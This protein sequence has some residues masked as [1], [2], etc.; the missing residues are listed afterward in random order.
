MSIYQQYLKLKKEL[1]ISIDEQ[2]WYNLIDNL[3]IKLAK[4]ANNRETDLQVKVHHDKIKIFNQNG[5]LIIEIPQEIN[6][7]HQATYTKL[8][9]Q[10]PAIQ[11][12][13]IINEIKTATKQ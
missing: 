6:N 7:Y 3:V 9:K 4:Y 10:L 8:F 5:E 2:S 11:Q 13:I 1:F 12:N